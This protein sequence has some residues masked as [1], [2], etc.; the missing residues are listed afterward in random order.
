MIWN[1]K[2][3]GKVRETTK[4]PMCRKYNDIAYI[5]GAGLNTCRPCK[6]H[7]AEESAQKIHALF[8]MPVAYSIAYVRNPL[9][10]GKLSQST[11]ETSHAVCNMTRKR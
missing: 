2:L 5:L 7:H 6:R 11:K 4:Y 3:S 9:N 8:Y 10:S 1:P